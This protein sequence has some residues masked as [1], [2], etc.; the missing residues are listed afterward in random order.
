MKYARTLLSISALVAAAA[1]KDEAPPRTAAPVAHFSDAVEDDTPE[2][3]KGEVPAAKLRITATNF[4]FEP[5]RPHVSPGQPV[6]ITV[7]NESN[8]EHNIELDI[9]NGGLQPDDWIQPHST[10]TLTFVAPDE[11]GVYPFRCPVADHAERG[12][13]GELVVVAAAP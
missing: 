3:P 7:E 4:A 1:C 10:E 8:M 11:P 13:V 9:P 5:E 12:M 2:V 6:K